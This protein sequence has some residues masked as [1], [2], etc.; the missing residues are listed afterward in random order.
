[1][2]VACSDDNGSKVVT[3]KKVKEVKPAKVVQKPKTKVIK[4]ISGADIFMKCAGCHGKNAETSALG[5]SK[6]IKS[7]DANKLEMAING[8]KDGT[9]GGAMKGLMRGQVLSLSKEEVKAVS[10]YISK[11]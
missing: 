11:L 3:E 1:M 6:I 9:Y 2:F 5:K 7:W 4:A 8:Y 10:E